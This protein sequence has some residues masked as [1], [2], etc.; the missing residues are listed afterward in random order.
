[1]LEEELAY[2]HYHLGIQD[3]QEA[4]GVIARNIRYHFDTLRQGLISI[5]SENS[6]G[7]K[8]LLGPGLRQVVFKERSILCPSHLISG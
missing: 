3:R 4:A 5:L 6:G 2:R 8:F 7:I 1:M